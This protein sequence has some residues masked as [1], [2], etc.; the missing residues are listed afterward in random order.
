VVDQ[1]IRVT[2]C[3]EADV[4]E[5]LEQLIDVGLL[6]TPVTRSI[7]THAGSLRPRH[8]RKAGAAVPMA[9]CVLRHSAAMRLDLATPDP[10]LAVMASAEG[11]EAV[12]LPDSKGAAPERWVPSQVLV[13]SEARGRGITRPYSASRPL[14]AMTSRYQSKLVLGI[15]RCVA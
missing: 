11:V 3:A 15:R 2:R 1:L 10:A 6:V 14:R 13:P 4:L 9:D 12:A 5:Q 7:G 8:Y